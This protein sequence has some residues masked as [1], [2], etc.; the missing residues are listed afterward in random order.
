MPFKVNRHA[1]IP[2]L[3]M[4][5]SAAGFAQPAPI[6]L[7]SPAPPLS[8][9]GGSASEESASQEVAS[10]RFAVHGQTTLV[11]QVTSPFHAPYNGPNSLSARHG[12][13]TLDMTLFL[14]AR[15]WSGARR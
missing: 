2:A 14:G 11:E 15:L 9:R 10:E 4:A 8:P 3:W 13:E 12:A 7:P 1:S 5:L 6:D